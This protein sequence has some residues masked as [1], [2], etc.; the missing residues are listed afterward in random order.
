MIAIITTL[1][2]KEEAVRIGKGLLGKRL[3]ACYNLWPIES[4]YWWK[5]ELLEENETMIFMKTQDKHYEAV[6]KFITEESGYD[7]PEVISLKP[8][9]ADK[10]FLTWIDTETTS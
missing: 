8:E 5:G 7:V 4:A 2:K 6:R 9:Q 10:L 3:I 1:H